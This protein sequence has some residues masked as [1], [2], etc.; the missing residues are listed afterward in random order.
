MIDP[1]PLPLIIIG[2]KYD[3]FQVSEFLLYILCHYFKILGTC[4][5]TVHFHQYINMR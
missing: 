4:N 2:G 3:L 5:C 1:F